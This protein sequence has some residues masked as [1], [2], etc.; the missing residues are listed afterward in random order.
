MMQKI[1]LAI[2][3]YGE[4]EEVLESGLVLAKKINAQILFLH[5]L[6]PLQVCTIEVPSDP[7]PENMLPTIDKIENEQFLAQWQEC[8]RRSTIDRQNL[9]LLPIHPMWRSKSIGCGCLWV[10][11]GGGQVLFM[12]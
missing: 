7:V 9:Y 2:G 5:V 12:G 8:Q 10:V 4:S 3:D 1:L 11:G 6:D